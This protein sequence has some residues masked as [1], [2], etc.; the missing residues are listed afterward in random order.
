MPKSDVI[1]GQSNDTL[2]VWYNPENVD[3]VTQFPIQGDVEMVVRDENRTEVIV[4][5]NDNKVAYELDSAMIEFGTALEE[6]NLARAVVFLERNEQRGADV[7]G[8]WRRLADVAIEQ[9]ELIIAQRCFASLNDIVRVRFIQEALLKAEKS[10]IAAGVDNNMAEIAS[11]FEIKARLAQMKKQF[12][13]AERIY[14]EN[15]A[16]GEAIEMHQRVGDWEAAIDLARAMNLP[17][18][19][20][21]WNKYINYLNETGQHEKAAEIKIR[22]GDYNSGFACF[23]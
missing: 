16:L 14:L 20:E 2:C 7:S 1:V 23:R 19:S 13:L 18:V 12:K 6:L 17:N 10:L 22:D 5:E 21:L 3:R 15:N 11:H 9:G 4:V 8:M